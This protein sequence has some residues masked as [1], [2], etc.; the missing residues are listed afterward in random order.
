[1]LEQISD[2]HSLFHQGFSEGKDALVGLYPVIL[3]FCVGFEGKRSSEWKEVL[4]L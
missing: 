1:M 3:Y 4:L 2:L